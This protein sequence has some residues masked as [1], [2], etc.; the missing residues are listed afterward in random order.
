MHGLDAAQVKSLESNT[1]VKMVQSRTA[2]TVNLIADLRVEQLKDV[3]VRQALRYAI[4]YEGL[5]NVVAGGYGEVLQTNILPG[6]LGYEAATGNYYKY[7][8]AKAK[9]LLT[10]AGYPNG[11]EI[12]L[13]SRDGVAG[14][15]IYSKVAQ[16]WQQNLA[17]VGVKAN[18]V[19][20]TGANM[21]GQ[22]AEEKFRGIGVTGAGATVFDPD[23]P[24]SV[25]AVQEAGMLGWDDVD[26]EAAKKAADLT[27]QGAKELDPTKRAAI[28]AE[29]S[30]LLVERSPY[31]TFIQVV[32][33]VIYRSN[34][35][36]IT[37]SPAAQPIDWK[38]LNKQ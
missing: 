11:F 27:A 15:V 36:G 32:E 31:W 26:P 37:F 34:I 23:N 25:R 13:I 28:Y 38:Y 1:A 35:T 16:F 3:R 12:Q 9:Q 19:E 20:L 4:D 8:P 10:E 14:T 30:K 33:P 21:W 6:R 24:A 2:T 7:D 18:I 22:I 29:I 5:K 17:Q